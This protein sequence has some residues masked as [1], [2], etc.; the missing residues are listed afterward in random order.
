MNKDTVVGILGAVILVAAMVGIFY[1]E[2]TQAPGA[3]A[4]G[5]G[6][7]AGTGPFAVSWTTAEKAGTAVQGSTDWGA[8]ST[9]QANVTGSN[10]TKI[11]FAVTWTPNAVSAESV[12]VTGKGPGGLSCT[13]QAS[14]SGTATCDVNVGAAPA[15]NRT[16]GA[17]E[18]SAAQGL[19]AQYTTTNGTG[20]WTLTIAVQNQVPASPVPNPGLPVSTSTAWTLTPKVTSYTAS[21]TRAG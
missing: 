6:G 8:S 15:V 3:T 19:A 20:A 5:G 11:S 7:G 14:T 10:V 2:G 12:T 9:Q 18:A 21:V 16:G 17:D 1:Y 4:N 13:G